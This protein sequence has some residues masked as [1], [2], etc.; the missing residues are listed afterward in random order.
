MPN[1]MEFWLFLPQMRLT[2]DQLVE[3]ARAA[4]AAGFAGVAGMDHL[5]PPLAESQPMFEAMV[6]NT[7]LASQTESLRV[8]SLVLCDSFRHPLPPPSS[9][10]FGKFDRQT[11]IFAA[12]STSACAV[13]SRYN[14]ACIPS[15]DHCT[16]ANRSFSRSSS[17]EPV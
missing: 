11:P 6:T 15:L 8:G 2:M 9:R 17:A 5:T 10:K 3:R 13:P 1:P 7:W 16:D 4:E 14:T 12:K